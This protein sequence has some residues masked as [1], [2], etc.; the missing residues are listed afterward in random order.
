MSGPFIE[1]CC[2]NNITAGLLFYKEWLLPF[3]IGV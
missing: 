2:I 1:A 3:I